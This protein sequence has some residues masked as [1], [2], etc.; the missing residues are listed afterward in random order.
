MYTINILFLL[1][2][3]LLWMCDVNDLYPSWLVLWYRAIR[4]LPQISTQ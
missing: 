1:Y 2:T 3:Q 4:L